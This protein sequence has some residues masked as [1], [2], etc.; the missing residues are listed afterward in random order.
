MAILP[1][2]VKL[3]IFESMDDIKSV[4]RLGRTCKALHAIMCEKERAISQAVMRNMFGCLDN[5][6]LAI[7]TLRARKVNIHNRPHVARLLV[8]HVVANQV[9]R[10]WFR[11]RAVANLQALSEPLGRL[12]ARAKSFKYLARHLHAH[13]FNKAMLVK[14]LLMT[15]MAAALFHRDHSSHQRKLIPSP[16]KATATFQDLE[17]LYWQSF[18]REDIC[19]LPLAQAVLMDGTEQRKFEHADFCIPPSL[20]IHYFFPN[21]SCDA[22]HAPL[23]PTTPRPLVGSSR[24]QR[25]ADLCVIAVF[26][27]YIKYQNKAYKNGMSFD[28]EHFNPNCMAKFR[29]M[30]AFAQA[31]GIPLISHR[32]LHPNVSCCDPPPVAFEHFLARVPDEFKSIHEMAY[33]SAEAP[34]R[35]VLWQ[36]LLQHVTPST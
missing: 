18:S 6:P 33:I 3:Q 27:E 32:V 5:V 15:E 16:Y 21:K 7:T 30:E 4:T 10:E 9:P 11:F 34:R 12:M 23:S 29:V 31:I 20:H 22:G 8:Y 1:N 28:G 24:P 14:S 19:L 17:Q 13:R 25:P 2:E 26:A 36:Q 35:R